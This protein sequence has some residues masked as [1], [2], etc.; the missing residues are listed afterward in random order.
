MVIFSRQAMRLAVPALWRATERVDRSPA[1]N[2]DGKATQLA[3]RRAMSKL[4]VN[5][6]KAISLFALDAKRSGKNRLYLVGRPPE[7]WGE[8][9]A[10]Q[11]RSPGAMV[12]PSSPE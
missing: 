11:N 8:S 1:E 3:V 7:R 10:V 9:V 5:E 6:A 2:E 4:T 12:L